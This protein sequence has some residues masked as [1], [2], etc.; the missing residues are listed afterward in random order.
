MGSFH[1]QFRRGDAAMANWTRDELDRIGTADELQIVTLRGN[2]TPR[3]PVTIWVVRHGNDLYVRSGYGD[4]AAWYRGTQQRR[5]GHIKAGASR[6]MSISRMPPMPRSTMRSMRRIAANTSTTAR[7]GSIRW[8]PPRRARRQSSLCR[9]KRGVGR[10]KRS[11]TRRARDELAGFTPFHP[12]YVD[13]LAKAVSRIWSSRSWCT[14]RSLRGGS[15][16]LRRISG[17]AGSPLRARRRGLLRH[18]LAGERL[19]EARPRS[20]A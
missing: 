16:P 9:A 6:R 13:L 1:G 14:D 4:R 10:V 2:G 7:N 12:P 15:M 5:D 17:T 8:S 11:A 19:T 3:K 20:R 18:P